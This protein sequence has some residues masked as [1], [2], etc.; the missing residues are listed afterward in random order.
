EMYS[1]KTTSAQV[2]HGFQYVF[3]KAPEYC[4][5]AVLADDMGLGKTLQLLVLITSEFEQHANLE[6]ALVVASVSLLE[7]DEIT[8]TGFDK[9]L[10][11]NE[12][13]FI[14]DPSKDA[15]HKIKKGESAPERAESRVPAPRTRPG[16]VVRAN[17]QNIDYEEARRDILTVGRRDRTLFC[18]RRGTL[19]DRIRRCFGQT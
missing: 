19:S 13:Q 17:I 16:L 1:S 12:A 15:I 3:D 6:P 5:G 10:P 14:L 7:Q 18:S 11:V 9:P 2:L 4:R 8:L